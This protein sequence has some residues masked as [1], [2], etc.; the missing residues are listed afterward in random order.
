[1]GGAREGR[2]GSVQ[3][4]TEAVLCAAHQRYKQFCN[5]GS[6]PPWGARAQVG[7]CVLSAGLAALPS[8]EQQPPP[9]RA[10]LEGSSAAGEPASRDRR[11]EPPP[12]P[13]PGP[14]SKK[15]LRP[16][17]VR[18]FRPSPSSLIGRPNKQPSAT[19]PES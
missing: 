11:R 1:M 2:A 17:N 10:P 3:R 15:S 12:P 16:L 14:A 7:L 9:P 6:F 13:R 18:S 19:P 5:L 8:P 4:A